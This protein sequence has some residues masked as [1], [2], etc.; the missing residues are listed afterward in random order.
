VLRMFLWMLHA[1]AA[2]LC[3]GEDAIHEELQGHRALQSV[4]CPSSGRASDCVGSSSEREK[5]RF[6]RVGMHRE[7]LETPNEDITVPRVG[8]G[9]ECGSPSK[10][11]GG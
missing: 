10:A 8:S 1:F 2:T 5:T 7:P 4:A 9:A 3:E 6:A 11:F